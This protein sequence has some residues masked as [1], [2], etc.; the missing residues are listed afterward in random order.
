MSI[1]VYRSLWINISIPAFVD[2]YG[3][4]WVYRENM[5]VYYGSISVYECLWG[6]MGIYG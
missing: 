5:G 4:V 3:S 6:F 1:G 2:I